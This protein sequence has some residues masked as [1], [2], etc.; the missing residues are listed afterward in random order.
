VHPQLAAIVA[1]LES[2]AN[3]VR[4]LHSSLSG[5]AWSHHP[6]PGRWSPADCVTHLNLM[7][8]ALL[9]LLRTSL[10][11]ADARREL[12]PR[13][14]HRDALGWLVWQIVGPSGRVKTT[15]VAAFEPIAAHPVDSVVSQFAGFQTALIACVREADGLPLERV[16][17][18]SPI[19][20]RIKVNLYSALTLV[21]RHQHR[22]LRQAELAAAQL[23][24]MRV[25]AVAV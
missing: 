16:K 22:H 18:P 8:E 21:P 15:T 13:R 5:D 23:H 25:P 24:A 11:R 17:V 9:P 20:G 4:G 3:R 19:D 10:Q 6:A 1:D 2:A 7:S 14:Y 12:P